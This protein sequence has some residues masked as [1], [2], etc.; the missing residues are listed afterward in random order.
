MLVR[1]LGPAWAFVGRCP[2]EA[3]STSK[4]S[5]ANHSNPKQCKAKQSIANE[6]NLEPCT[7]KRIKFKEKHFA[8]ESNGTHH[9]THRNA[10]QCKTKLRK[11][12]QVLGKAQSNV[13]QSKARRSI[14]K[15]CKPCDAMHSNASKARQ[16]KTMQSKC[17]A[18]QS[19]VEQSNVWQCNSKQS[20]RS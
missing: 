6:S 8:R 12:N 5:I 9:A 11:I 3:G 19:K 13:E 15:Q 10:H 20:K 2:R 4:Q 18:L 16:W 14:A 7:A 17:K 1:V